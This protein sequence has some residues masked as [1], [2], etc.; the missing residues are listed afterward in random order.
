MWAGV[1][2]KRQ[3]THSG[4]PN[5]DEARKWTG[6]LAKAVNIPNRASLV[7]PD[8]EILIVSA[9]PLD[10]DTIERIRAFA[11]AKHGNCKRPAMDCTI[12]SE[13][14]KGVDLVAFVNGNRTAQGERRHV[15][16]VNKG[17]AFADD[18]VEDDFSLGDVTPI[19]DGD[20]I[21]TQIILCSEVKQSRAWRKE[22]TQPL[23]ESLRISARADQARLWTVGKNILTYSGPVKLLKQYADYCAGRRL[24]EPA[25][26]YVAGLTAGV[27]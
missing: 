6:Q 24:Y 2:S 25:W 15:S 7:T 4:R 18:P 20:P 12:K 1:R 14:V 23:R 11:R 17:A 16:W 9:D 8:G 3:Y 26:D 10:A 5:A 19:P 22:R 21:P 27:A 13:N